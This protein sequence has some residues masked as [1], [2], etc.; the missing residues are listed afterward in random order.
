[1][2][3]RPDPTSIFHITHVD[4]VASIAEDGCL[5]SDVEI[6]KRGGPD[7]PVGMA[8]IKRRRMGLPIKCYPEDKVGEY[9]PFYF[10]PRS[11]ML[12]LLYMGN[13]PELDY[14]EGQSPIVHLRCDV[15]SVL[16]WAADT[17]TRWAFTFANAGAA[18]AIFSKDPNEMDNINW[19]AVAA[20]DF[21]DGAIKEAKQ[22]EFLV[23]DAFPWHLVETIG[24]YSNEVAEEVEEALE[25]ASHQPVIEVRRRWYF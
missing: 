21:R 3:G 4:N 16:S 6:V 7:V 10:C 12:Y 24:V 9:V 25:G 8:S 19:E 23:K 18:Y 15:N 17:S 20:R 5:I 22:S 13:H 14:H 1:M 2:T 11:V